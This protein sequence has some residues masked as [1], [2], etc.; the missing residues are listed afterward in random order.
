MLK[1]T[2]KDI[3][4]NSL[5]TSQQVT[6]TILI[7]EQ[8]GQKIL[9]SH[10]NIFLYQKTRN[11]L[12]TS[13]RYASIIS[14]FYRFLSTQ[15]KFKGQ[16]LGAYHMLADNRDI[17]RWQ[18]QR[19]VERLQ[20]QSLS[21]TLETTFE[22]AKILLNFF[23]WLNTRGFL[24][25][26]DVVFKTWRANFRSTR[27]LNYIQTRSRMKIDSD[28][29]RVL[30]K[31][32]RQRQSDFLITDQEIELL[33]EAYTDPVYAVLF[34]LGLGTA[35]RPMDLVKFP[36]YGNGKNIHIMPYSEMDHTGPSMK[37]EVIG[38]KGNKDREIVINMDDLKALEDN[39]IIP[40]YSIRKKLYKKKYRHD[41]PPGILFL[42]KKGEPVTESMIA[43][44]TNDA[45][46]KLLKQGKPFR[47]HITFYQ[48][49]HWW[50][51]QHIIATFGDRLLTE[52]MEVLYAA[53]SQAIIQQLGHEDIETTY[54]YYIDMARVIMMVHKGKTFDLIESPVQ[55]IR[56]FVKDLD[57]PKDIAVGEPSDEGA[58]EAA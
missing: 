28:N 4:Y 36:L 30:E 44:R 43:S 57:L 15:P 41:C 6:H 58:E 24:T 16:E 53:T 2:T 11:S 50:P 1:I 23:D 40:Y 48:N 39:Y 25:N 10:P 34:N 22:D 18:V 9:L 32:S 42:N 13:N 47:D 12:R 45:K 51:T 3:T 46:A 37:Y 38:S 20:K 56:G 55:T 52:P 19:Q 5:E 31:K 29:I 54:K 17:M 49:R 27:M 33:L 7:A 14:M 26:V 35:M 8:R 21:P